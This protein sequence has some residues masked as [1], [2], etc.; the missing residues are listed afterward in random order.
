MLPHHLTTA[1]Q[2]PGKGGRFDDP[3]SLLFLAGRFLEHVRVRNYSPR[4][5]YR[6][7]RHLA[8]F[9]KYC[10][11]LGLTQARQVTR[12]V[13]LSYQSYLFH[14]KKSDGDPLSVGTQS[15]WLVG[16]VQFFSY[17][18]KEGLIL[19]NP[20]S[21]I[22]FPRKEKRLP[23]ALL[24]AE[25]VQT[26]LTSLDTREP[27][28][29]R[30][31]AIIETL[32]STG[33]RRMELCNLDIG[34]IDLA[35]G[36][37]RVFQGK[38]KKDRVVPIGARAIEWVEKYLDRGAA[39]LVPLDEPA[40]AIP[41]QLGHALHGKPPHEDC[42]GDHPAGR[43]RQARQLPPVPP[44]VRH[45]LAVQRLRRAAHPDHA[46]PCQPG[47][48]ADLHAPRDYRAAGGPQ[49][50]SP[51]QL[52]AQATYNAAR[53]ARVAFDAFMIVHAWEGPWGLGGAGP[54][55]PSRVAS[56]A[57][58]PG[59]A[60]GASGRRS[61]RRPT[62]LP[63][64]HDPGSERPHLCEPA[65][66]ARRWGR[67]CVYEPSGT[68]FSFLYTNWRP[69]GGR[70]GRSSIAV[71]ATCVQDCG[72][73][74][75][76]RGRQNVR[77]GFRLSIKSRLAALASPSSALAGEPRLSNVTTANKWPTGRLLLLAAQAAPDRAAEGGTM[78]PRQARRAAA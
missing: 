65:R 52:P 49:A 4:T 54:A 70:V 8:Y 30:D 24:S 60:P 10:E 62:G 53:D 55:R 41:D 15:Q 74:R 75:P 59:A 69:T 25:D 72:A 33:I 27:A 71:A 1:G 23:K 64:R 34:H 73:S 50:L 3:Q 66:T 57:D 76:A 68:P 47:D 2:H 13:V 20:A 21:D 35:G 18:T 16:L 77:G 26:I 7:D 51:G 17:L 22:D 6:L 39:A 46:G 48:D 5:V 40:G 44:R 19:Y 42:A 28:G 56:T 78:P 14:Y 11:A 9:R 43:H 58:P 61:R 37:V 36:L 67:R 63:L 45:R 38:G 31:R 29:I 32:Y 12:A